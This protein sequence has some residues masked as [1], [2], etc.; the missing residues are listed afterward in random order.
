MIKVL[1]T[2][3]VRKL[4]RRPRMRLTMRRIKILLVE[5]VELVE[6]V[7]LEEPVELVVLVE[8][9]VLVV[10]VV[11]AEMVIVLLRK[12]KMIKKRKIQKRKTQETL[13]KQEVDVL[14]HLRKPLPQVVLVKVL[15]DTVWLID[16]RDVKARKDLKD[17]QVE[18]VVPKDL[19]GMVWQIDQLECK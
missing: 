11:L 13:M 19:E 1:V 2:T 7:V 5:M 4:R 3:R 12:K 15:V 18:V 9:A 16:L 10:L 6:L 17:H 8:L 14:I